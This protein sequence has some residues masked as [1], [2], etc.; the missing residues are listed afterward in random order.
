MK[1]G[2][3]IQTPDGPG[4]VEDVEDYSFGRRY[5]VM[6][7]VHHERLEEIKLPYYYDKDCER[8]TKKEDDLNNVR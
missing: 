3:R 1:K 5:G 8:I 2:N 7:D 6:L 4:T